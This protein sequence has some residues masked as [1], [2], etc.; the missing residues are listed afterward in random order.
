MDRSGVR[1]KAL[2][3]LFVLALLVFSGMVFTGTVPETE[4]AK[5]EKDGFGYYLISV[6]DIAVSVRFEP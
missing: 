4:A 6:A 3:A 5:S 1:S 2:I